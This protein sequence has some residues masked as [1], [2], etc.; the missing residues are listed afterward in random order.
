MM[1]WSDARIVKGS[2]LRTGRLYVTRRLSRAQR[3]TIT[4]SGL[5]PAGDREV[6][7]KV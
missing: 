1:N 7:V 3:V 5:P 6:T 2:H 4:V